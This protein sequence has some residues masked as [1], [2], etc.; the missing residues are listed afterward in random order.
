MCLGMLHHAYSVLH[1]PFWFSRSICLNTHSFPYV[2]WFS[3]WDAWTH[4]R[5]LVQIVAIVVPEGLE[6]FERRRRK[7]WEGTKAK[8][9]VQNW[10][11]NKKGSLSQ[12]CTKNT[13][14][15]ESLAAVYVAFGKAGE[16]LN[17]GIS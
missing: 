3:A 7:V 6:V 11:S 16:E 4:R 2:H 13:K 10:L 15:N 1:E 14:A 12:T 8:F 5:H 17:G 9:L